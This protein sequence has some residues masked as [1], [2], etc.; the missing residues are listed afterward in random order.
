MPLETIISVII[1]AHNE[2]DAIAK[3]IRDVPKSV[4]EIG[5]GEYE[6]DSS[7]KESVKKKKQAF[8]F[9]GSTEIRFKDIKS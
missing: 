7:L 4:K 8:Q 1:P 6:I 2:A 9:F 5:P 3:V